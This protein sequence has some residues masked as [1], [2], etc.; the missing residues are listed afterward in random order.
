MVKKFIK[1]DN[2]FLWTGA[3]IG[4]V[5]IFFYVGGVR[6]GF[7]TMPSVPPI[8][9]TPVPPVGVNNA[10]SMQ[11]TPPIP[12]MN[13]TNFTPPPSVMQNAKPSIATVRSKLNE[14]KT[15]VDNM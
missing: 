3:V 10:Q 2:N 8:L 14:L 9:P 12:P 11:P 1:G 4:V 15:M 6:E 7:Q 13:T 5:L